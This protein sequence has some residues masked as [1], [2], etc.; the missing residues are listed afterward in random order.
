M[1]YESASCVLGEPEV[2][3]ETYMR[4]RMRMRLLAS[5]PPAPFAGAAVFGRGPHSRTADSHHPRAQFRPPC[6]PIFP[7]LLDMNSIYPRSGANP[8]VC[9]SLGRVATPYLS[10]LHYTALFSM[11][12]QSSEIFSSSL[13]R[14]VNLLTAFT[15]LRNATSP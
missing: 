9:R 8:P 12:M 15:P 2:R 6:S 5:R 11:Q 4:M 1:R 10:D 14:N 7:I 3:T 13:S